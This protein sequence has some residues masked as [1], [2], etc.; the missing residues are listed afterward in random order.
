[1][2]GVADQ[3]RRA[4]R[5]RT[6]G[7]WGRA[8]AVVLGGGLAVILAACVQTGGPAFTPKPI[9]TITPTPKQPATSAAPTESSTPSEP[10]TTPAS[11]AVKATGTMAIFGEVSKALKG[12]CQTTDA[13]PT[14]TLADKA[15][16][17]YG[18]VATTVVL[19]P[20]KK[21]VVAVQAT[22][23]EDS[24]GFAWV[25]S[26]DSADPVAGTSAKLVKAGNTYTISGKL[27]S[28]ETRKGKTRTEIL[29]FTVVARCASA[30]W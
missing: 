8:V 20:A 2:V 7:R 27:Q 16:E 17:F 21:A 28:K 26:Y 10:S 9:E 6:A 14:I 29:P 5:R 30:E 22:F 4:A 23:E 1:M 3:D 11:P 18:T 15:N 25:L 12:T 13:G 19:D 24:E